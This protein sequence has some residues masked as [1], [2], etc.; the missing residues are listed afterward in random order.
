MHRFIPAVLK[1]HGFTITEVP[2]NHRPRVAGK[3]KYNNWKRVIKVSV[4]MISLWFWRKYSARPLHVF[5][6]SGIVLFTFSLFLIGISIAD[7]LFFKQDLSDTALFSLSL[8]SFIGGMILFTSGIIADIA[9]KTYYK[10]H[11]KRPYSVRSVLEN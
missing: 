2:V 9:V 8:F 3:S 7:H 4:D 6:A 11:N 5:G 1:W 10:T